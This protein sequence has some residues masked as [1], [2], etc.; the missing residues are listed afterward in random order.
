MN[1][2]KQ[3][4]LKVLRENSKEALL[5]FRLQQDKLMS[6]KI[7]LFIETSTDE[8]LKQA[9]EETFSSEMKEFEKY[10]KNNLNVHDSVVNYDTIEAIRYGFLQYC[11]SEKINIITYDIFEKFMQLFNIKEEVIITWN[12]DVEPEE[13]ELPFEEI[14]EICELYGEEATKSNTFQYIAECTTDLAVDQNPREFAKFVKFID[15][16]GSEIKSRAYIAYKNRMTQYEQET[17]Q[18]LFGFETFA[19]DSF[20]GH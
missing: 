1:K 7:P 15:K 4:L 20:Y 6:E 18:Y 8:E 5:L 16:D 11:I 3:R 17:V 13:K 9:M 19:F 12:Y 2:L 10:F 14:Q